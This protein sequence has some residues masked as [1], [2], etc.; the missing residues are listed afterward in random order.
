MVPMSTLRALPNFPTVE[1]FKSAPPNIVG[2]GGASVAVHGYIDA[3]L[4]IA[5]SHVQH[6]L[7]VVNDLAFLC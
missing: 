7:I 4:V 5:G 6:P 1:N 2:L 3:S